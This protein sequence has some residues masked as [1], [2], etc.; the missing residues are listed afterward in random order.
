MGAEASRSAT[1]PEPLCASTPSPPPATDAVVNACQNHVET[2]GVNWCWELPDY[3][4]CGLF[5]QQNGNKYAQC[6]DVPAKAGQCRGGSTKLSAPPECSPLV[7]PVS[8]S[9][10]PPPPPECYVD[11]ASYGIEW[12]WELRTGGEM[13]YRPCDVHYR[14]NADQSIF[15]GC[16]AHP[17]KTNRCI[18]GG[19]DEV[20][21]TIPTCSP[22]A[23]PPGAAF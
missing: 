19:N 5:Y 2:Q 22:P 13:T 8:P 21:P 11:I 14:Y 15:K 4:P 20:W 12:C 10:P 23:A 6:E 7:P 18:G 16:V 9:L 3:A 17:T 1:P